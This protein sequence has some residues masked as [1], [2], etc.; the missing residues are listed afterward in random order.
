V[1]IKQP[2]DT[3]RYLPA[4]EPGATARSL[5][6][7][8]LA[9]SPR[10]FAGFLRTT[11]SGR[12][13]GRMTVHPFGAWQLES[14][15]L[16]DEGGPGL[17]ASWKAVEEATARASIDWFPRGVPVVLAQIDGGEGR[18]SD[19]GFRLDQDRL[20]VRVVGWGR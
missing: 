18:T 10:E 1:L 4:I 5:D 20:L 15:P 16:F 14:T 3:F 8:D 2:D 19:S 17:A 12:A 9:A 13:A 7:Q 11:A 6:G